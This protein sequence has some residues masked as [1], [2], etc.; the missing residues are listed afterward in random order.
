MVEVTE[1]TKR[2]VQVG[3]NRRSWRTY[4][5]AADL[6]A[7]AGSG[8]SPR[9]GVFMSRTNGPPGSEPRRRGRRPAKRNGTDGSDLRRK[10]LSANRAYYTSAGSTITREASSPT[11]ECT[12]W[13]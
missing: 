9:H 10:F 5:E 8:T 1:R 2:V 6:S 7:R 13:T 4:K 12:S 11:S 3:T